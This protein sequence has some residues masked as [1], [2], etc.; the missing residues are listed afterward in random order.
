MRCRPIPLLAGVITLIVAG[1]APTHFTARESAKAPPGFW[2]SFDAEKMVERYETV[3]CPVGM[4][5]AV[6]DATRGYVEGKR[7]FMKDKEFGFSGV[8]L[9]EFRMSELLDELRRELD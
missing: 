4:P 3:F 6:G 9:S 8:R 7:G 2:E 5:G 1:C